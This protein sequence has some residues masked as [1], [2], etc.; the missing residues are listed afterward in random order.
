[1]A[2]ATP[3]R[4]RYSAA[5]HMKHP[6]QYKL[7]HQAGAPVPKQI[8][9][10]HPTGFTVAP[11]GEPDHVEVWCMHQEWRDVIRQALKQG[12]TEV[13]SYEY[14][15]AKIGDEYISHTSP[16]DWRECPRPG[17]L[18]PWETGYITRTQVEKLADSR[19][20]GEP[21]KH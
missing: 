20:P 6:I 10:E 18:Q 4:C 11:L 12:I 5:G 7:A 1:M 16:Q 3:A 2:D 15:L 19:D 17:D 21:D 9:E 13:L 8:V 14:G